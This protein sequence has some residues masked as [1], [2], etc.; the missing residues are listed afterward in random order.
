MIADPTASTSPV[1]YI[2]TEAHKDASFTT[3]KENIM[4]Q[5][6]TKGSIGALFPN[7]KKTNPRA[8]T[9]LGTLCIDNSLF[10]SLMNAYE[11]TGEVS[12]QV[13]AWR[14]IA[15]DSGLPYLTLKAQLPWDERKRAEQDDALQFL[16][17]LN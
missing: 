7:T 3:N 4:K 9:M 13:S 12:I 14:N 11:E 15:A 10:E 8:P 1:L 2:H 6:R 5:S 17:D 16:A